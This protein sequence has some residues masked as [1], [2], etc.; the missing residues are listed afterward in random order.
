MKNLLFISPYPFPID[1]GLNQHAFYFMKALTMLFNVYCVFFVPPGREIPTNL[2][3]SLSQ[4]DIKHYDLCFL[5]HPS[6]MGWVKSALRAIS[7]FP[8]SYMR[9]CTTPEGRIKIE[10][11]IN[12]YSIDIVHF[13]YFN[14][15]KYA[16][17]L[18]GS[19]KKVI[20][21]LDLYHSI[22]RQQ[23]RF[24]HSWRSKLLSLF[25]A[26]K[27]YL[28]ERLLDHKVDAK[29]FLNTD[30]MAVLPKKSVYIPHV[31]N[32]NILF[33]KP[34][35]TEFFN[36][37]FLGTYNHPPNIVS[38]NFIIEHILPLLAKKTEKFSCLIFYN[39]FRNF[40]T[41]SK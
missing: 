5:H 6:K 22:Y 3:N 21:Y 25:T 7:A 16:F 19:F 34:R 28:F 36:I 38:F 24:K 29:V 41:R 23:A 30:E 14:Y 40:F 17:Q 12:R 32:Q 31:V 9:L 18:S 33:R 10:N 39:S 8:G 1:K 11:A 27:Y 2:P 4:L 37:L 35:E 13:E 15:A 26:C 20:V